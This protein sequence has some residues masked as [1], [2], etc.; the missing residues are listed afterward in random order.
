[1]YLRGIKV[2]KIGYFGIPKAA[3]TSIK[4]TLFKIKRGRNFDSKDNIAQR[5]KANIHKFFESEISDISDCDFRFIVIRDPI[6]RFLSA[7]NNRV[8][9]H[10]ELTYEAINDKYLK[11]IINVFQ[12]NINEFINDFQTYYKVQ[13]INHHTRPINTMLNDGLNSF[14]HIYK[15]EQLDSLKIDLENKLNQKVHIPRLQINGTN[16]GLKDLDRNQIEF[17]INFYLED[18]KILKNYYDVESIWQEWKIANS[19][20]KELIYK[21]NRLPNFSLKHKN[22][23]IDEQN[24][25]PLVSVVIPVYNVSKYINQCLNSVISQSYAKIEIIIIDDKG[26][27][28]SISK[29]KS[30]D[31]KRIKIIDHK[32]NKGLSNARNT[33]I[34]NAKGEFIL[35]LDSDDYIHHD[36]IEK[37]LARQKINNVDIVVF[38]TQFVNEFGYNWVDSQLW[39]NR[40]FN[41]QIENKTIDDDGVQSLVC[42]DVASWSK[43][44]RLEYLKNNKIFFLENH[45]YFEDHYFCAKLYLSKG[46]FSYIDQR[47]HYY[48]KRSD[49]FNVSITQKDK[50]LMAVHRAKAFRETCLLIEKFDN[51]Y[52]NIFYQ[53]YFTHYK[54][55]IFEASKN[56]KYEKETYE[57]FRRVFLGII[58]LDIVKNSEHNHH[59]DLAFLMAKYEY[60]QF[61][62]KFGDIFNYSIEDIKKITPLAYHET[63]KKWTSSQPVK[64]KMRHSFNLIIS[65]FIFSILSIYR[66]NLFK[67]YDL[68]YR[69]RDFHIIFSIGNIDYP[70][71]LRGIKRCIKIYDYIM[72]GEKFNDKINKKFD[73]QNY[74]EQNP[75]LKYMNMA[76]YAHFLYL[77]KS[78]NRNIEPFL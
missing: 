62:A 9:H 37:C 63:F 6:K 31:D 12:P 57:N 26:Q 51:K 53:L 40:F 14:T 78:Q 20:K 76:L 58:H 32:S 67:L 71:K 33:G 56:K 44:I 54:S 24:F 45:H 25:N 17:L 35:F 55:I 13:T 68:P 46:R 27:D 7:Y 4:H 70:V 38:N 16:I 64:F 36:L 73:A 75:D 49:I 29:V 77:A 41:N 60:G 19:Y 2:N 66:F 23:N 15:I 52:K 50:P 42:W 39:G 69:L 74:L 65:S 47:L 30:Y 1:M 3:G 5:E 22:K 43:L 8:G 48:L 72:I 28:D 34:N 10:K 59:I 18:Y 11:K 21:T 61:M